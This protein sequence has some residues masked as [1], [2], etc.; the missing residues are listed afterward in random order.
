[1]ARNLQLNETVY[2][3]RV[4]LGMGLNAHS[5]FYTGKIGEVQDRSVRLTLPGGNLTDWVS[6][7]HVHRNIGVCVFRIGDFATE[8]GLLDPLTKSIHHYL[9]MLLPDDTLRVHY[10]RSLEELETYWSE[11]HSTFSH[12]VLVGHG[13][14][15]GIKFGLSG[16]VD[17]ERLGQAFS[18]ANAESKGFISLCCETGYAGF[19]QLFSQTQCCDS[20][21]APFHGLHGAI[22]SQFCQTILAFLLLQGETFRVAYRHARGA[23]PG[24]SIFRLWRSGSLVSAA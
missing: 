20:I 23:V 12:V 16:W 11:E 7:A 8:P 6:A 10:L 18:P 5:A 22:A 2:V 24:G 3:P 13:R 17:P 14:Q 15:D 9:R 19:G 21:V 4:R 1:M